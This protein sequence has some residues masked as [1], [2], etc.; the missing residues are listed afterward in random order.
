[1]KSRGK[2]SLHDQ[3]NKKQEAK[4]AKQE[5]DQAENKHRNRS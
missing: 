4:K 1:M 3:K 2:S 5:K